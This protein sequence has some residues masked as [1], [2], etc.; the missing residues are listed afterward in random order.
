VA[1]IDGESN[2]DFAALLGFVDFLQFERTRRKR[3]GSLKRGNWGKSQ[4]TCK[5]V[6]IATIKKFDGEAS[7]ATIEL[8]G[9]LGRSVAEQAIY[10]L[11]V[12]TVLPLLRCDRPLI[13]DLRLHASDTK[14]GAFSS[15]HL[16]RN[17]FDHGT[18]T[19]GDNWGVHF[20]VFGWV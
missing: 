15:V 20:G 18:Y 4:Q 6:R 3:T 5:N 17:C 19:W 12:F 11:D 13:L 9:K 8:Q 10:L 16:F 14:N 2:S 1:I 7:L